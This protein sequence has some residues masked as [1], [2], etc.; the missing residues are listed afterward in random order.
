MQVVLIIRQHHTNPRWGRFCKKPGM[1]SSKTWRSWK[2]KADWRIV[3]DWRRGKRHQKWMWHILLDGNQKQ[4]KQ[5]WGVHKRKM[6]EWITWSYCINVHLPL[7]MAKVW[8]FH[9]RMSCLLENSHW[10]FTWGWSTMSATFSCFRKVDDRWWIERERERKMVKINT[11]VMIK[12]KCQ[13]VRNWGPWVK[14]LDGSLYYSFTFVSKII[15]K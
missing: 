3:S 2:T 8:L 14:E 10:H 7:L 1:T 6:S 11:E 9:R 13:N 4:K 12:P 15:S 5:N